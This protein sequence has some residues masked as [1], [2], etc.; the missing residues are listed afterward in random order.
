ML[1]F[2][3]RNRKWISFLTKL[4]ITVSIGVLAALLITFFS[5][6]YWGFF[7][8]V[9]HGDYTTFRGWQLRV[10]SNYFYLPSESERGGSLVKMDFWFPVIVTNSSQ[11]FFHASPYPDQKLTYRRNYRHLKKVEEERINAGDYQSLA[12]RK[13]FIG[14]IAAY[15]VELTTE[16]RQEMT[17][18]CLLDQTGLISSYRGHPKYLEEAHTSMQ[19]LVPIS[20]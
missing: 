14:N 2:V 4:V 20:K 5:V 1:P 10:P 13:L 19:G 3:N 8:H 6:P 18:T 16:V 17:T 12:E 11:V 7:W 15:C 9:Q